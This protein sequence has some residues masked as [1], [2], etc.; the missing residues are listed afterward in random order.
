MVGPKGVSFLRESWCTCRPQ[1]FTLLTSVQNCCNVIYKTKSPLW[2]PAKPTLI[3]QYFMH[4][5]T[6][7]FSV[8]VL[9]EVSVTVAGWRHT[10]VVLVR[11]VTTQT[12]IATRSFI[13]NR[14]RER[15]MRLKQ[16]SR[17][18]VLYNCSHATY[19][20]LLF[21]EFSF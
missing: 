21:C 17:S 5:Q 20:V 16:T 6:Y 10:D 9:P 2:G 19:E 4:F 14:L 15:H 3:G 7:W 12:A 8:R 13:M 18:N 11:A 1:F